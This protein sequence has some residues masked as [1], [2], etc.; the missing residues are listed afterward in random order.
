VKAIAAIA[1]AMMVSVGAEQAALAQSLDKSTQKYED[2]YRNRID[3]INQRVRRK[4]IE[5]RCKE[6]AKQ[7]YGAVHFRERRA[8][9]KTCIARNGG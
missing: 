1:L 3:K 4:Q 2:A 7:T 5:A 9:V 8:Y 6:E